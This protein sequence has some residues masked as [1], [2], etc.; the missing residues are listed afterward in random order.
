MKKCQ[1]ANMLL[2]VPLHSGASWKEHHIAWA[3]PFG[4]SDPVIKHQPPFEDVN[5]LILIIMPYE[6]AWG[7]VP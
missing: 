2:Y 7:T 6:C 1:L 5:C 4:K 3:E